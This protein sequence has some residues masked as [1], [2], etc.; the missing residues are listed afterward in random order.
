V[1]IAP[2]TEGSFKEVIV[3][4]DVLVIDCSVTT[5]FWECLCSDVPVVYLNM[6]V[7]RLTPEAWP[8]IE[9]RCQVI[10]AT[11]DERNLPQLNREQLADA[12]AGGCPVADSTELRRMLAG[13]DGA[14]RK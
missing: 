4:A 3:G 10:H 6:D 8:M 11:Y 7:G 12:V 9:R 14:S 5:T 1:D 13:V 2:L